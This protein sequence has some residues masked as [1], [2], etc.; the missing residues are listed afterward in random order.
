[1]T[2]ELLFGNPD[3]LH[4]LPI[5]D[6]EIQDTIPAREFAQYLNAIGLE[7]ADM[8]DK[9]PYAFLDGVKYKSVA[10]LMKKAG[11]TQDNNPFNKINK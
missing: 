3:E 1:M 5:S 10:E 7:L 4:D 11:I 2:A 9:D 6:D 8:E